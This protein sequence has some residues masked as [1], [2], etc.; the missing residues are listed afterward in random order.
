MVTLQISDELAQTIRAEA[1][2]LGLSLEK[3]LQR[4]VGRERT[5]VLRRRIEQEQ[6]WW[7]QQPLRERVKYEGKIVAIYQQAVI[8]CDEDSNRLA[9]RIRSQF[10]DQPVL[11]IP[12]EGPREITVYSPHRNAL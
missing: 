2:E 5:I 4:A 7:L 11:L 1:T 8:D 6:L 10:G 12:A 3:Y 9:Q